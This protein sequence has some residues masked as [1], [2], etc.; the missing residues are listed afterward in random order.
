MKDP[1]KLFDEITSELTSKGQIF[2]TRDVTNDKGVSYKEYVSFPDNLKGYFDFGLLHGDKEFLVYESERFTFNETI[3][4]AAQ[5]GN[6]L[7][8]EGIQKGDRVAI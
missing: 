6:A 7:I 3:S 5:V 4:K 8:A 1:N 2:E